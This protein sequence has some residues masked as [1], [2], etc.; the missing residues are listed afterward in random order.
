MATKT[1]RPLLPTWFEAPAKPPENPRIRIDTAGG[2]ARLGFA[3]QRSAASY[4][5]PA[6]ALLVVYNAAN[7][8]LPSALGSAIDEGI[9]PV[10]VGVSWADA[11][12]GFL[13]WVGI[14][15]L[16]YLVMNVSYRFGTRLGWYGGQR[17]QAELSDRILDRILDP[18]G[19]A[20]P[21]S[22][23]GRLLSVAT[24]DA[25]RAR[26]VI[27]LMS[28]PV[29]EL[30]AIVVAAVSLLAIHP[31][32]GLGVII[33]APLLLLFM[34]FLAAPLSRRAIV[35]QE[36]TADA[37]AVA[38]DLVTGYRVLAGIHGQ[39]AASARFTRASRH[40][41]RGTIAARTATGAFYGVNTLATG[42]F[43]AAVTVAAAAL[44]FTGQITIGGLIA[45]AGIS[46]VLLS[47]LNSFI[48]EVGSTWARAM[49][50][51]R[52]ILDL[53]G[54]PERDDRQGRER[55]D[56]DTAPVLALLPEGSS[57]EPAARNDAAGASEPHQ[58]PTLRVDRGEFLVLE[59]GA[60]SRAAFVAALTLSEAHADESNL[61]HR[62]LLHGLP[63]PSIEPDARRASLLVAPHHADLFDAS[64]LDNVALGDPAATTNA[65]LALRITQCEALETEL[66]EG[67]DTIVGEDGRTLSGGQRQ[68]VALARAIAADPPL[69]ILVDPTNAVDSVTESE[70]AR[71]VH[72]ARQGA[73][74]VVITSSPA[75]A[76]VADR[77]VRGLDGFTTARGPQR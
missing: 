71:R 51:C 76:A 58:E 40:A 74:T 21:P 6:A 70:I 62:I 1:R 37:T 38:T 52:R 30:A 68:R 43:A 46:Q 31:T 28:T 33:G 50:S 9:G 72:A 5:L 23:P 17:A 25:E 34:S 13:R 7:M 14:I 63:L 54:A 16:L 22:L 49:G 18:R 39:D 29:G 55:P 19:I 4:A 75:F 24:L 73:T 45:A 61:A 66:P 56:P 15:A 36:R 67:F 69:L 42:L 57:G 26:F 3:I 27:Y 20:G 35:E 8:L 65:R 32:L 10:T 60:A 47:P 64:I 41:L 2:P 44:A 77:T 12:G 53:L 48:S 11:L 59:L